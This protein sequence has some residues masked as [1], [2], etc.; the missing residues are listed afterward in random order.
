MQIGLIVGVLTDLKN[1]IK[2]LRVKYIILG[3]NY[4]KLTYLIKNY[5]HPVCHRLHIF[6]TI[7][8]ISV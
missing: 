1:S 8:I 2:F 4:K 6:N 7:L 3:K 5:Y